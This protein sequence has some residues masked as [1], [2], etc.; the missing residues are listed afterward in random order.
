MRERRVSWDADRN[1][2]LEQMR[3]KQHMSVADIARR[4]GTSENAIYAQLVKLNIRQSRRST[5]WEDH[6]EFEDR[7][8]AD[9]I[10]GKTYNSIA[11]EWSEELGV[12][13]TKNIPLA[14][15]ARMHIMELSPNSALNPLSV[16]FKGPKP[17][18]AGFPERG[19]LWPHGDPGDED[20]HFCGKQL[21]VGRPYCAAHAALAYVKPSRADE[22]A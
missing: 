19:C 10:A 12:M 14:K 8:K 13:V 1:I 7:L 3:L 11:R 21:M 6:P 20:F 5:F 16:A 4:F 22:A 15:A 17:C 2:Q 9:V 18:R